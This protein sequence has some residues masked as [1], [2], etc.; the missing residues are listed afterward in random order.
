MKEKDR[1]VLTQDSLRHL[2]PASRVEHFN[3]A[4]LFQNEW[5][6]YING[7]LTQVYVG[8]IKN[9]YGQQ[10]VI[11]EQKN[12][13]SDKDFARNC[14]GTDS[15]FKTGPLKITAAN[16]SG[17]LTL[18]D[19]S[20]NILIFDATTETFTGNTQVTPVAT[21]LTVAATT[22]RPIKTPPVQPGS[23]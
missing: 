12:N 3:P 9:K 14:Y 22:P 7:E 4:F 19:D 13:F 11:C 16:N 5:A 18:G 10:G 2:F 17:Q 15:E 6:G 8:Y 1:I 21:T 23:N 20:G